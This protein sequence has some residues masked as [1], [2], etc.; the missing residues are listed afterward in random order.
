[1]DPTIYLSQLSTTEIEIELAVRGLSARAVDANEI[2]K[3]SLK[4]ENLDELV[5]PVNSHVKENPLTEIQICIARYEE[6]SKATEEQGVNPSIDFIT[7]ALAK[8]IHYKD[9]IKRMINSFGDISNISSVHSSIRRIYNWLIKLWQDKQGSIPEGAQAQTPPRASKSRSSPHLI[10]TKQLDPQ[11]KNL[12]IRS[13]LLI[14]E[15][16]ELKDSVADFFSRLDRNR[17][18]KI[19]DN[20]HHFSD[21]SFRNIEQGSLIDRINQNPLPKETLPRQ[22]RQTN[23]MHTQSRID[24]FYKIKQRWNLSF[25]GTENSNVHDFIFRLEQMARDDEFPES[26]LMRVLHMFLT[27]KAEDWYWI[28]KM[29]QPNASWKQL[30]TS[31]MSYFSSFDSEEEIREQILRRHQTS[32]E[33]FSDYALSVQKLNARL[34]QRLSEKE[35]L[36][37]LS[38]NM[39]P[40]L[41]NVTL[42]AT[43][44]IK[45]VEELRVLCQRYERMWDQTG[46]DPRRFNETPIRRRQINDISYDLQNLSL[47]NQRYDEQQEQRNRYQHSDQINSVDISYEPETIEAIQRPNNTYNRI[48]ERRDLLVCWNCKDIGH[49]Y[50]ECEQEFLTVFCFGCGT[51]NVRKPNCPNCSRRQT[52][53]SRPSMNLSG[54]NHSGR[55]VGPLTNPR[56]ILKNPNSHE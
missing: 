5:K 15:G 20:F 18:N 56:V 32:K 25:D 47:K 46:Y 1:M 51:S 34:Q 38:Q 40:A 30:K 36:Y 9:R 35:I 3:N 12:N 55:T 50:Q 10:Q 7:L 17:V 29:D 39:L 41:K 16:N 2:L 23:E 54:V 48:N 21:I 27:K 22:T 44:F 49:P 28:F 11:D 31:M 14:N 33:S 52:E 8:T 13:Q 26:G 24:N 53:N 42:A 19:P 6:L 4:A 37:R 43:G 45:T